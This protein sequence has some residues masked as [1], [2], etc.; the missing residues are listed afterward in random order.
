MP[1]ETRDKA[2]VSLGQRTA[3]EPIGVYFGIYLEFYN[4]DIVGMH[5][6]FV[7]ELVSAVLKRRLYTAL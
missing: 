4:I 1:C 6:G 7:H 2:N 5:Q 3:P